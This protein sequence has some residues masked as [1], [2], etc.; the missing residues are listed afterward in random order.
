[1]N[2]GF[3]GLCLMAV[4]HPATCVELKDRNSRVVLMTDRSP[5]EVCTIPRYALC[6]L[7]LSVEAANSYYHGRISLGY[8]SGVR[9]LMHEFL[10][11]LK[12][13]FLHMICNPVM[14][15]KCVDVLVVL[16]WGCSLS[17]EL[18]YLN[19]CVDA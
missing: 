1:M 18:N 4:S 10:F 7:I 3:L 14:L 15:K 9:L 8:P 16:I 19:T 13:C 6:E 2:S 5:L 12:L 17:C 11:F